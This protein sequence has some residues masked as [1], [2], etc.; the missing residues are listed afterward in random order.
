MSNWSNLKNAIAD[1]IKQNG[2]QEITGNVMQTTLTSMVN[3]LGSNYQFV[4][5]ATPTTAPGTPDGFVFYL[6][7]TPGT[8]NNFGG[9]T[10]NPGETAILKNN[11]SG[12]WV[13][14]ATGFANTSVTGDLFKT[15]ILSNQEDNFLVID[16]PTASLTVNPGLIFLAYGN[17][18][19]FSS[20]TITEQYVV[21]FDGTVGGL[22]ALF[23]DLSTNRFIVKTYSKIPITE[24]A[25]NFLLIAVFSI[26]TGVLYYTTSSLTFNGRVYKPFNDQ[27][28]FQ[29]LNSQF[30]IRLQG[31]IN[32][33]S[34]NRKLVI[35]TGQFYHVPGNTF[36]FYGGTNA[37]PVEIP[38]EQT[39]VSGLHFV[40]YDIKTN[41]YRCVSYQ[42]VSTIDRNRSFL[43]AIFSTSGDARAFF[44]TCSPDCVTINGNKYSAITNS[45]RLD[46][47]DAY[48]T[49]F[50][51]NQRFDKTKVSN[52]YIDPATGNT[53]A[54]GSAKLSDYIECSG[55]SS[56]YIVTNW[57]HLYAAFGAFYDEN[58][59]FI[60][61]INVI[62][63]TYYNGNVAI[64]SNAK[65]LR[66]TVKT[67]AAGELY[68]PDNVFITFDPEKGDSNYLSVF[69]QLKGN[70]TE[71]LPKL[72]TGMNLFNG[73]YMPGYINTNGNG[74]YVFSQ[75]NVGAVTDYI[76][77][78]GQKTIYTYVER[79]TG[80]GLFYGF[81]DENK[82]VIP[83][84][85]AIGQNEKSGSYAIPENAVYVRQG[86]VAINETKTDLSDCYVG[87]FPYPGSVTPPVTQY[88]TTE[89]RFAPGKIDRPPLADDDPVNLYTLKQYTNGGALPWLNEKVY[90]SLGDSITA[91]ANGYA[92][93]IAQIFNMK[94][95]NF[96]VSGCHWVN[97]GD[98]KVDFSAYPI[99]NELPNIYAMNVIQN[100]VYRILQMITPTT[101]IV[102]EIDETTE[103]YSAYSYPVMGTGTVNAADVNLVTIACGVND[104][105]SG[106]PIGQ[107]T[108][109]DT[110]S[111]KDLTRQTLWSAMKWAI[112][113]LRIYLPNAK[114]VVLAP[115][116]RASNRAGLWTYV[117]NELQAANQFACPA[118]NMFEDVGIMTEIEA[119]EHRYL[120]DGLHPNDAGATLMANVIA[121]K[122]L[123]WYRY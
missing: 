122:L 69:T 99:H 123:T 97:Y 7:S 112:N 54:N 53:I 57:S 18:F 65:Y 36:S 9:I 59:A 50:K 79:T 98:T 67:S 43:L 55:K 56:F 78:K 96:G 68:D 14:E 51:S 88:G 4:D 5:I 34:T 11:A 1:V 42:N 32:I 120:S 66:M 110:V 75:S 33:D 25:E 94:W 102:P 19:S 109:V 81:Y 46:I 119:M 24:G 47:W 87:F 64:P 31:N 13:K 16:T 77:C 86:I 73:K 63:Q 115:I 105:S 23:F 114:I 49:E 91:P 27:S 101:A 117:N 70:K 85:I 92:S 37:A 39:N 15:V 52:A 44:W 17:L 103:F 116:Q 6:T 8:Y 30:D 20:R 2:N 106:K 41:A 76:Y 100:Q 60:S 21:P 29:Y 111:Y 118:V 121:S 58:K 82:A 28:E 89:M 26:A 90:F 38:F 84:G 62:P 71:Y 104:A 48:T 93:K 10:I 83:G 108:D 74:T 95:T 12:A 107:L 3:N 22:G 80:F 61:H 35:E 72:A 40:F 45:N 113:V